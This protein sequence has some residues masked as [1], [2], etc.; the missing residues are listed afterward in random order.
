VGE[1]E[2]ERRI[3]TDKEEVKWFITHLDGVT[4]EMRRGVFRVIFSYEKRRY[5]LRIFRENTLLFAAESAMSETPIR[6]LENHTM[7]LKLVAKTLRE[8]VGP[9][10]KILEEAK[11]EE[12]GEQEEEEK[13]EE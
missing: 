4:L 10:E 1:V 6:M 3:L 5:G 7:F 9:L 13:C 11:S 8:I 12:E 2:V